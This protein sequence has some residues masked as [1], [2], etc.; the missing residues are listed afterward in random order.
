MVDTS[1]DGKSKLKQE[2]LRPDGRLLRQM[3]GPF[4]Q[5]G[6]HQSKQKA[7]AQTGNLTPEGNLSLCPPRLEPLRPDQRPSSDR[8]FPAHTGGPPQTGGPQPKREALS[9]DERPSAQTEGPS[10]DGTQTGGPSP[11]GRFLR[12]ESSHSAQTGASSRNASPITN[13]SVTKNA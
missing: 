5:A 2:T 11:N 13:I 6:G 4:A 1:P 3:E 7:P 8:R 12:P 10:P 9:P